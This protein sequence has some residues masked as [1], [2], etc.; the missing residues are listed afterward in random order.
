MHEYM[1]A[2]DLI[3]TKPGGE[4]NEPTMSE[5]RVPQ[6]CTSQTLI[7]LVDSLVVA[8]SGLTTAESLA[9]GTAMLIVNPYPGQEMR[10]TDNLLEAGIAVKCND[11]YLLGKK[12]QNIVDNPKKLRSMQKNSKNYGNSEACFEIVDF[13]AG[14]EYGY[15]DV[16]KEM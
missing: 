13:I 16:G 12:L 3:I 11:L 14:G 10:N 8:H 7:L 5:E 4:R 9:T 15:L 1:E 6:L 2:A